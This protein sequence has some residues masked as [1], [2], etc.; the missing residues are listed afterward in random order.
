MKIILV[1]MFYLFAKSHSSVCSIADL[2]TGGRWFDSKLSQYS[3]RELMI[4]I[5]KGFIP[6]SL[7]SVVSMMVMWESIQ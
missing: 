1:Y 2:R 5:A 3:F 4:V 7:L 6:L